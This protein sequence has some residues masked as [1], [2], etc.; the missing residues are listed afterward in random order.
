LLDCAARGARLVLV[1]R[2]LAGELARLAPGRRHLWG[3]GSATWVED[4]TAA[5]AA[6]GSTPTSYSPSLAEMFSPRSLLAGALWRAPERS[7]G[8][9]T[10]LA[11]LAAYLVLVVVCGI[12]VSRRPRRPWVAWLWFPLTALAATAAVAVAGARWGAE[13]SRLELLRV[14]TLAPSGAGSEGRLA[15]LSGVVSGVYQLILPWAG[16][17]LDEISRSHRFG[18]PFSRSA[19]G[20]DLLEDRTTGRLHA[21]GL[22][23]GRLGRTS[24][25]CQDDVRRPVPR[26]ERRDGALVAVNGTGRTLGRLSACNRAWRAVLDGLQPGEARPLPTRGS[27]LD[28]TFDATHGPLAPA[29]RGLCAAVDP[30]TFV[31]VVADARVDLPVRVEPS[32]PTRSRG[33]DVVIGPLPPV[34][35]VP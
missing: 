9:G 25:G 27:Q 8:H 32:L 20:I 19:G 24:L 18:S 12:L 23:V 22:A 16:A 2:D 7:V 35:D 17:D 11:V 28:D 10:V 30:D 26:L 13:G 31:M 21:S 14:A 33:I 1:G 34:E 29:L 4:L 6:S 15:V 3:R 5:G